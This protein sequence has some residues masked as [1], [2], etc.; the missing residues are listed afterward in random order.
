MY[1]Q[2]YCVTSRISRAALAFATLSAMLLF[3]GIAVPRAAHADDHSDCQRRIEHAQARL[4][5]AVREHGE[6]SPQADR[7]WNDLRNERHRCWDRYH[8]WYDARDNQWHHDDG[9]DRDPRL[10]LSVGPG[11]IQLTQTGDRAA[12]QR[13]VQRAQDRLNRAISDHG[14]HSPQADRAWMQLRDE[15]HRCWDRF[16]EWWDARDNQW[17][18]DNDWNRD[19]RDHHDHDDRGPGGK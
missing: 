2:R 14:E 17:R 11:G 18:R 19:P 5:R 9:W 12:C 1:T 7:A 16:H 3:M 13:R 6:H 15:R 8:E 10:V 4:D